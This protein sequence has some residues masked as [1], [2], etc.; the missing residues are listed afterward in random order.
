[1]IWFV[2]IIIIG[3]VVVA[4]ILMLNKQMAG[5]HLPLDAVPISDINEIKEMRQNPQYKKGKPLSISQTVDHL[6]YHLE[7]VNN[8]RLPE[9]AREIDGLK[10]EF[11]NKQ[12]ESEEMIRQL[13]LDNQKLEDALKREMSSREIKILAEEEK[14]QLKDKDE[15]L[16]LMRDANVQLNDENKRLRDDLILLQ[17]EKTELLKKYDS[18]DQ[19]LH[20]NRLEK[21]KWMSEKRETEMRLDMTRMEMEKDFQSKLAEQSQ[22]LGNKHLELAN[23]KAGLELEYQKITNIA[24]ELK[25]Q[26]SALEIRC[27]SSD[28]EIDSLRK[29]VDYLSKANAGQVDNLKAEIMKL[30]FELDNKAQ[31]FTGILRQR[32][33]IHGDINRAVD[34]VRDEYRLV[35]DERIK[36]LDTLN[37]QIKFLQDEHDELSKEKRAVE[38][39]LENADQV[40]ARMQERERQLNYELVKARAQILGLERIC[41]DYRLRVESLS[42]V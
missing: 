35:V 37:H 31:E 32:E 24:E 27:T 19:E 21:E 4:L 42:K 8:E 26:K 41:S 22:M 9:I 25:S 10:G 7:V 36:Q 40:T 23:N 1:M 13:K 15:Q 12:A 17:K 16:R 39:K 6:A 11:Q 3:F 29:Q 18:L 33:D 20:A 28:I 14:R 34:K 38:T 5:K 30:N 2:L